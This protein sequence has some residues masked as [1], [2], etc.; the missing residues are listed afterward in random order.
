MRN[1]SKSKIIAFRQ[2][3]KRLWLELH[4][5]DLRDDSGSEM[6]F[7]IGNQVGDVARQIYD[8]EGNGKLIDVNEN[9]WDAAYS[10]TS[11]WLSGTA[12]PL[13]EA[14]I[15]IEGALALADV[16]LPETGDNGL[17]WHMLEVKSST[18]VKD[19]H[20]EDLAVQTYIAT[21]AGI[22][23]ASASLAHVDNSFVYPGGGDY[24]GLLKAVDLTEEIRAKAGEVATWIAE[25]QEVAALETEPEVET[26]PQ[27][28]SPF[29]C[30]FLHHCDQGKVWPEFPITSFPNLSGWRRA[31]VEAEDT[32]DLREIPDHLLTE[33]QLR[34]KQAC[35][36]GETYFDAKG[37]AADLAGH[38]FPI[39]F[40]DFET[41]MFAVP[42]WKGT[43]PYQQIPFQFSLHTLQMGGDLKHQGFLDLSGNDP[44]LDCARSLVESL[45]NNGPIFAYNSGFEKMVIRDLA[46]RFFDLAPA[47][48][49]IIERI[50]DLKPI[51]RRRFYHPSQGKS[52]SLKAMLPAAVPE[53]S[54]DQLDGVRDGGMAV[55]AFMEALSPD[56]PLRRK[57]EISKQLDAYCCLDTLAMVRL[58]EFFLG[59]PEVSQ[60]NS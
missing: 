58:W 12:A 28:S 60:P 39:Y 7:A 51:A 44:S 26:G 47:L 3:P 53:L 55:E 50:E 11:A 41:A 13:F 4:R 17:R 49:A 40:L 1:L 24:R 32:D 15:R 23:L 42:I 18:G 30:P 14:A 16:M 57:Q 54:Y 37:A 10:E 59:A 29:S 35:V 5:P 19:Y 2:C 9:G 34:V 21:K 20:R 6:V 46:G 27:C 22:N 38:G 8:T 31:A 56:T 48:D 52:W 33:M 36:S 25:A 45:G 43:R